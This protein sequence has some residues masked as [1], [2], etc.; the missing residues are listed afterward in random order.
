MGTANTLARSLL[1]IPLNEFTTS[2]RGF[3]VDRLADLDFTSIKSNGYAF[4]FECVFR[5]SQC[6]F[7]MT[8]I[9]IHFIDRVQGESKISKKEIL[10][11]VYRIFY[12]AA[13]EIF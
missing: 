8:E 3:R 7:S 11:G 2:Y 12:L 6:G 9:P 10:L 1:G 4:F 13:C 5:M